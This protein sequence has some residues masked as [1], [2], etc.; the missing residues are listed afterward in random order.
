V[1]CFSYFLFSDSLLGIRLRNTRANPAW[2]YYLEYC[3]PEGWNQGVAGSPYLLIRR[4]VDIPGVGQRPA[5]LTFLQFNQV[6]GA[7][8]TGVE[9]SGNVR[10]TVEVTNLP[11]PILKVT[12]EAL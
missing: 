11:G 5:Y 3:T 2:D 6:V 12:A 9:P 1:V 10:F 8:A 4:M 7:G